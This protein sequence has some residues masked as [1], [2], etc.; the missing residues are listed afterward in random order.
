M[1][2]TLL[3]ENL[4][5]CST[6]EDNIKEANKRAAFCSMC[7]DRNLNHITAHQE[8]LK[9]KLTRSVIST[10][11]GM[12][13]GYYFLYKHWYLGCYIGILRSI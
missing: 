1:P 4:L 12:L 2:G 6:A 11:F 5:S 9:R 13:L 3:H 8:N 10:V 7:S